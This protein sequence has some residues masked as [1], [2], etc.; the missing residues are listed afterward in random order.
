M[1]IWRWYISVH[2]EV[3]YQ[4]AYRGG[5]SVSIWRWYISVHME[6]V[7]QCVYLSNISLI[8]VVV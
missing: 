6:V 8:G 2:M 5:I 3:V 1:S 4:C 7:Y